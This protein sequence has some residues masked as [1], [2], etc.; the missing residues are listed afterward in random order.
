[1]F[2]AFEGKPQHRAALRPGR[3]ARAGDA[4]FDELAGR[5]PRPSPAPR[6]SSASTSSGCRPRAATPCPSCDS[7]AERDTLDEWA[8]QQGARRPRR[9]PGREEPRTHRR[10]A[11]PATTLVTTVDPI[12]SPSRLDPGRGPAM[13]ERRRRRR[14]CC[15]S[16]PTCRGSSAT[17][18]CRSSGSRCSWCPATATP[19]WWCPASRRPGSSS[20]P[21]CSPSRPW[22]E[23][24]DPIALVAD[25][26][27]PAG[28]RRR[29]RP[30]L[31]PVRGRPPGARCR[32]P[33]GARASEVVGPLRAAKDAAEV[34]ALRR[35]GRGRRP[36]RRPAPGRR[37]P[38]RRPH[39]GRGV[40]RP[41]PP[42]PRR[43]PPPGELRHRRR[44]RRT[45]P[46]RTTRPGDRVIERRRGRAVR[47]RRHDA[48]RR[49]RRLLLRH[50]PLRVRPGRA[51]RRGG[52]GLRRAARGA[53]RRRWP[54]AT[55]G[56][57]CEDVDAA[58][59]DVDR[60]RP[61]AATTSST[62]PATA[63]ASRS[64]RTPT[65]SPAT[66]TPLAPGHAFSVE[67]GIYL[68]GRLGLP[69]RGHRRRHRRPA[70]RR[71]TGPTTPS[72]SSTPEAACRG[73]Q[74]SGSLA[75]RSR[76]T[77]TVLARMARSVSSDQ[78]ST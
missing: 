18:R 30:H 21:T 2:C 58:A 51:A 12:A 13:A 9:V 35:A 22:E 11:G 68:P 3:G 23:T 71:S 47:L 34:D 28:D 62:A 32:P 25:L 64:T 14:C 65:S 29:R 63:S 49:R 75:W 6:S 66:R 31:G 78:L 16:G 15:R 60:R 37:H 27:G 67:P 20:G 56:T 24:D 57:P 17:R 77:G 10:A 4:G 39:R 36:G 43:G 48:R 55:V 19:R 70:P 38:A 1:M 26:L 5:L 40:G 59:R 7:S 50:H 53:G 42:P 74:L 76:T 54:P 69:P 8:E 72:S 46:A 61:A 33:R 73:R 41:R 45:P 44:R 52:R